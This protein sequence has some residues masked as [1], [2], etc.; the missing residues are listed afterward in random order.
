MITFKNYLTEARMA[1]L[2]HGTTIYAARD[3]I[4]H[5]EL[6]KSIGDLG[7]AEPAISFTRS[8][9][10]AKRWAVQQAGERPDEAVVFEI[11]QQKLNQNYKIYPFNFFD[12]VARFKGAFSIYNEYEERI[13]GRNIKN[14]DKYVTK[15]IVMVKPGKPIKDNVILN[16]PKLWYDGKFINK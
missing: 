14:F 5:N 3:I 1:P 2:Y 12:N 10:F 7:S 13:V 15:L 6:K 9:H 4:K 16:Y 8:L 11:D